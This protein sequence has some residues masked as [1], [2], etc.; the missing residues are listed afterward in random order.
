MKN[1]NM[2]SLISYNA[3]SQTRMAIALISIIP[4]LVSMIMVLFVYVPGVSFSIFG[5]IGILVFTL[6]LAFCGYFIIRKYPENIIK[7]R[8][9]ISEVAEG[10]LPEQVEL[11]DSKSS[12]DIR[13]IENGFN[14]VLK[15]MRNKVA[16]VEQQLR[17]EKKLRETIEL[18]QQTLILAEQHRT[19]I[20]SLGAACHHIGQPASV[21]GM[22][23][24]LMKERAES[25]EARAEIDECMKDLELIGEVL[26]N[27][28]NVGEYKTTAYI[29]NST[30]LD[31]DIIDIDNPPQNKEKK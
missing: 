8:Q 21:L 26:G 27:L 17:V 15:E 2:T 22:H 28:K 19:M 24:Y 6:I 3:H 18:Q 20:Q 1:L 16:I 5:Q 14:V 13:F 12:D 9:Y 25:D 23:L 11:L 31:R 29:K 30:H 10:A 7:L 4:L